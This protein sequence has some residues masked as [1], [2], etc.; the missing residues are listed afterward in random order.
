M[1]SEEFNFLEFISALKDRDKI[2][3][4]RLAESEEIEAEKISEE[5]GYGQD[6]VEAV[7]GFVYFMR[8]NQKP[9]ELQDEHFQMF[10]IVCENLVAKKQLLP[11]VLNMFESSE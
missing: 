10:R 3:I 4:L 6:Y 5:K 1:I 2:D 8:Y 11:E 9:D 7:S